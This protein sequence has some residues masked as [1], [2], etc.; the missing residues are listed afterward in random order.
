MIEQIQFAKL[1]GVAHIDSLLQEMLL[2]GEHTS[3]LVSLTT[4]NTFLTAN[5]LLL[6]LL[7]AVEAPQPMVATSTINYQNASDSSDSPITSPM[8][9]GQCHS[10]TDQLLN[11]NLVSPGQ[12]NGN[13][14]IVN[15]MGSI[16]EDS[17]HQMAFK[18]EPNIEVSEHF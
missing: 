3:F 7:G 13:I 9:S 11:G 16:E 14:I 10:P 2:G 1:F 8:T 4:V 5:V 17:Y 15:D 12:Q 6:S 18:Q